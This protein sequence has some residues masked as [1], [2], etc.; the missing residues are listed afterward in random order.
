ME[1]IYVRPSKYGSQLI[2]LLDVP[3]A[4]EAHTI[5]VL[6]AATFTSLQELGDVE[7]GAG[8]KQIEKLTLTGTSGTANVTVAGGLT[9]LATWNT[10]LTQTAADFVTAHAAAYK[11]VGIEITS[12]A[13][14]I[15]FIS[16]IA[17]VPILAP[18]ITNVTL[19]LDGTVA[20]DTANK[21]TPLSKRGIFAAT[22]DGDMLYTETKFLSVEISAG[23]IIAY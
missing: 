9:K 19:T 13:A 11:A 5:K 14:I 2:A 1:E 18:V 22:A 8:V 23:K 15:S 16:Y 20:Q 10:S 7:T 6:T 21:T 3:H 17:G 4:I 12:S